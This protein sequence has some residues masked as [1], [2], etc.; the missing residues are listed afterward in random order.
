MWDSWKSEMIYISNIIVN[1]FKLKI[2]E[3]KKNLRITCNIHSPWLFTLFSSNWFFAS[4]LFYNFIFNRINPF[5]LICS[6]FW[7]SKGGLVCT[8]LKLKCFSFELTHNFST[9]SIV[10]SL[11]YD[12]P[13]FFFWILITLHAIFSTSEDILFMASSFVFELTWH[14]NFFLL[15]SKNE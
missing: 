1:Y 5:D 14:L 9:D 15:R 3:D 11:T 8:C 10:S 7:R 12:A 13:N 6:L 4:I 2:S